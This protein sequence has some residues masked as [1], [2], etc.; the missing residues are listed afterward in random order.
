VCACVP[1]PVPVPVPVL[2]LV[3]CASIAVSIMRKPLHGCGDYLHI[4]R[5][6]PE[7]MCWRS[8]PP[9]SSAPADMCRRRRRWRS[10]L[11]VV[12]CKD[13]HG[14]TLKGGSRRCEHAS[15]LTSTHTTHYTQHNQTVPT[16]TIIMMASRARTCLRRIRG[17]S[18][19]RPLRGQSPARTSGSCRLRC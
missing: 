18:D 13:E 12:P 11:S 4:G 14:N 5:S 16:T 9:P 17:G 7:R 15:L 3:P 19:R 1:V 6:H 10:T 2:M 8:A